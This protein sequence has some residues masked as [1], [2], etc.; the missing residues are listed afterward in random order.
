MYSMI[1]IRLLNRAD[2]RIRIN[3]LRKVKLQ[4]A[5]TDLLT[6]AHFV[7]DVDCRGRIVS[8]QQHCQSWSD[9]CSLAQ[10]LNARY[11]F[12]AKQASNSA[13]ID[14]LRRHRLCVSFTNG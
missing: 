5:D 11:E 6:G 9:A 4:G 2:Q 1:G 14:Y 7:A 12:R 8:H 10:S 3:R 13:A